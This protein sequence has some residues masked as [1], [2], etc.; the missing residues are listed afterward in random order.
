MPIEIETPRMILRLI[1]EG[2]LEQVAK[3][4]SDQ[5]V[6]KFFPDGIQDREQ[7]Q[8]KNKR[9]YDFLQRKRTSLFCHFF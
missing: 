3:L 1:K 6:R 8:E 9:V 7:N 5:E 2:D 4:N